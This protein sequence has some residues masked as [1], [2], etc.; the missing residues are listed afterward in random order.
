[1]DILGM[2]KSTKTEESDDHARD[3]SAANVD[4]VELGVLWSVVDVQP[5]VLKLELVFEQPLGLSVQK[6]VDKVWDSKTNNQLKKNVN[7]LIFRIS[8]DILK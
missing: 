3:C 8:R 5:S 2:V 1:M 6:F 4:E 7:K